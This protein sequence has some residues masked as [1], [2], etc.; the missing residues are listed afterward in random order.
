[1]D[2]V[3]SPQLPVQARSQESRTTQQ[4]SGAGPDGSLDRSRDPSALWRDPAD[5]V[6]LVKANYWLGR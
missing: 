4:R 3:V 1:M 5:N 6:F 2:K